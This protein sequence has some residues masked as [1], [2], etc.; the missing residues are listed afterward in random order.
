MRME[1]VLSWEIFCR[2]EK[3]NRFVKFHLHCIVRNLNKDKRNIDLAPTDKIL[4]TPWFKSYEILTEPMQAGTEF[5][6]FFCLL[7][8][9]QNE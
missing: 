4:R 1:R 6:S 2:L 7:Q 5:R 3:V 9:D 8:Q